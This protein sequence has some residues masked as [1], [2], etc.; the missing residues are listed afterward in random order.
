[1]RRSRNVLWTV[2]L[3]LGVS[4]MGIMTSMAADG[5]ISGV[6]VRINSELEPGETLPGIGIVNGSA[7][8]S[9]SDGD[10][11]VS[12]SSDKYHI[13]EAEWVTSTSKDM[14]AGDT[15]EMKIWLTA[16]GDYYFKGSYRS[17]N[18]NVKSGDFVSAKREDEDTLV[19][20][21]KVNAI[22]GDFNAPEN[23][24]WKDNAKGTARWEKPDSGGT[25]KYEVVLRRGS[26]KVHTV[27]TTSTSYN[28]YPYMTQAGTYT[29]RV[30]TIA[31]TSKESSYGKN[32]DWTESDEI[33]IAKEDV[34]DGSGR[35]DSG[36][37]V[38][39][40][41]NVGWRESG[42]YW[43]YYYPDG[44]YQR[45][46]WLQVNGKWYLF[47]EDGKMLRGWQKKNNNTYLLAE[48][49]EMMT[50]WVK[51][52][53]FW[54]YLNPTPDS[55]QGAMLAN[56]WLNLD[57]KVYYFT[58]TGAMVEGWWQVDGNW[59]YFYP[60]AGNLAVNTWIDTFYVDGSGVWRR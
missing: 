15:P 4:A 40:N 53:Q 10:I 24:Y 47:Q 13:S 30:R 48:S 31:K 52:G 43:Y 9:V 21:A 56:H 6:T 14:K 32:S 25:G 51:S 3:A 46:S 42:G 33:Y 37:G 2:I 29:F 28:F 39:G 8:T 45:N 44:N 17:S 26:S 16:D 36:S 12:V 19:V 35:D 50:G 41:T 55:Y 60:G 54:Y 7:G 27:E 34:S 11:C 57:G 23:A 5:V 22:K 58:N 59:Y 18:V 1:M 49:G 38:V 20:R